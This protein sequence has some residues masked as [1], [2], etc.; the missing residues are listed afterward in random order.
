LAASPVKS[1]EVIGHKVSQ[2]K[3][4]AVL[5]GKAQKGRQKIHLRSK[6]TGSDPKKITAWSC[7][8]CSHASEVPRE[9]R[10]CS[11][12]IEEPINFY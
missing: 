3:E 2:K 1:I 12:G 8:S 6:Q 9:E 10:M 7:V 4:S 11:S 5:T